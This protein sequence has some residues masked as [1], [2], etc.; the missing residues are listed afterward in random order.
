MIPPTLHGMAAMECLGL[1]QKAIRRNL[2]ELAFEAA[3]ELI[4]TSKAF[5][6]MVANRLR[7]IAL[8]DVDTFE[9]PEIL[10][11]V[12][13]SARLM[14]EFYT[15]DLMKLGR[16]KL[17]CLAA[18]RM[19][20]AAPKCRIND[21]WVATVGLANLL[22]G[23]TPDI[24]DW[25]L[26]MHTVAGKRLGRGI[27]HFIEEGTKL[28]PLPKR[29]NKWVETSTDYRKRKAAGERPAHLRDPSDLFRK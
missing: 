28:K 19:L 2:P 6:T 12:D 14:Q 23:K 5:T 8:E 9:R 22:D 17:A 20:C 18:I 11:Y 1:M 15:N 4:H 26:D 29:K 3:V 10:P 21:D 13:T 24:P 25:A 16:V 7:V 27:D